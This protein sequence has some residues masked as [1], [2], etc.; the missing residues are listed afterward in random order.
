M[1]VLRVISETKAG[2]GRNEEAKSI[3]HN[4]SER[5]LFASGEWRKI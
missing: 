2:H 4:S 3:P 5:R 1:R